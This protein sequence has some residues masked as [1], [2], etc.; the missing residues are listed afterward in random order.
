VPRLGLVIASTRPGRVG[1]PVA[2]WV[3]GVVREHGAFDLDV[4]DLAEF[5]LPLLDEPNHPRLHRYTKHHTLA[6][7]A[8][9]D[10]CDAFVFVLPEYNHGIT[11]PLKN[12]IDYLHEEWAYKPVGLVSYGGVAGGTR[13]AQMVKQVVL[14]VRMV[15][16]FET[17]PIASRSEP[18]PGTRSALRCRPG[19]PHIT[20]KSRIPTAA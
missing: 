5:A 12:A 20:V 19:V 7:S 6:W 2:N 13:A 18:E 10:A 14:A 9:I 11:A 3:A 4:L 17:V 1:L 8:Q 16:V 15:P